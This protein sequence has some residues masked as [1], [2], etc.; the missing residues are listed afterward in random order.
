MS[1]NDYQTVIDSRAADRR[2][3]F[4][5]TSQRMGTTPENVE[6]DFWVCWV[7]DALYHRLP[8]G[9]PRLLFKGGT[10]LSKAYGLIQ[11]FSEDVDVTVFREDIDS[12]ST[13]LERIPSKKARGRALDS[14]REKC[15]AYIAHHL[16]P[17]LTAIVA[18]ATGDTETVVLAEDDSEGQTLIVRYPAAFPRPGNAS[19][20][21][22][23]VRIEF[24][25]K[26]ALDPHSFMTITPFVARELPTL[27]L[28]VPDVTTIDASRTFWDKIVI[29]HGLTNWFASDGALRHE[30][31]RVSRHYYDLHCLFAAD[32]GER[33]LSDRALG[34]D[35]VR[36]AQL[37]FDRPKF[38]L[39]KAR[40]GDFDVMPTDAMLPA[41]QRDYDAMSS[42]IFGPPPAFADVLKTVREI[43]AR[44]RPS[45]SSRAD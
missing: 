21:Q 44:L 2:D 16:K 26:S 24:G 10:S 43:D 36:H 1:A 29:A 40:A 22:P 13:D 30:G 33:A 14:I 31:Q 41:L 23:T 28:A 8:A 32:V 5:S 20:I 3:L 6:K 19:Y 45:Q 7:L 11:R 25:A 39:T 34:A 4:A 37:F 38:N 27:D 17:A 35:S 12:A 9:G 42:M 15:R 18:D